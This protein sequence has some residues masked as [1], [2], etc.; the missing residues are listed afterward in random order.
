MNPF[1]TGYLRSPVAKALYDGSRDHLRGG[2]WVLTPL[3]D[4]T[5]RKKQTVAEWWKAAYD[6]LVTVMGP[7]TSY[8]KPGAKAAAGV[9]ELAIAEFTMAVEHGNLGA[10]HATAMFSSLAQLEKALPALDSLSSVAEKA[11]VVR[12]RDATFSAVM[13]SVVVQEGAAHGGRP[14][15]TIFNEV[16]LRDTCGE[17]LERTGDLPDALRYS[18]K[19]NPV[20]YLNYAAGGIENRVVAKDAKGGK[21]IAY[22]DLFRKPLE[23]LLNAEA[24]LKK[25]PDAKTTKKLQSRRNE[26]MIVLSNL[27]DRLGKEANDLAV[28]GD[29]KAGNYLAMGSIFAE[30]M[31]GALSVD[32]RSWA[33]HPLTI[34]PKTMAE[35]TAFGTARATEVEKEERDNH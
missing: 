29:A 34:D 19:D 31:W 9:I 35:R 3:T 20:S 33:K 10:T 25:K 8:D 28:S 30:T 14:V 23:T 17:L 13:A 1:M 12:L 15:N 18:A 21:D 26:E 24:A 32:P 6:E 22:F 2:A 4:E 5:L 27:Q 11:A 7:Y 16:R